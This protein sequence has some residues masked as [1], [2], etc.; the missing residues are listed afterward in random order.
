MRLSIVCVC[1]CAHAAVSASGSA[2]DLSVSMYVRVHA[3]MNVFMLCY[4]MLCCVVYT[5]THVRIYVCRK[6]SMH[7]C[8]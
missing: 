4:I 5:K 8:G 3:C 6:V 7:V 2:H 1:L